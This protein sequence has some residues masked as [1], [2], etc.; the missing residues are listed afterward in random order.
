[1]PVNLSFDVWR[2]AG[3]DLRRWAEGQQ[4]KLWEA[5]A[6]GVRKPRGEWTK[7]CVGEELPVHQLRG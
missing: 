3:L 4:F 1:M 6:D 5:P 2:W 7:V